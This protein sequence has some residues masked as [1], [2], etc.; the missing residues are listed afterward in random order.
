MRSIW[1]RA[2]TA[3]ELGLVIVIVAVVFWIVVWPW[4]PPRDQ[5]RRETCFSNCKQLASAFEMYGQDYDGTYPYQGPGL[6]ND[7]RDFAK[8][9]A[10]TNWI[11]AVLPYTKNDRIFVCPAAS[12]NV[13]RTAAPGFASAPPKLCS[14][15]LNGCFNGMRKSAIDRPSEKVMAF[16]WPHST[17]NAL[18]RPGNQDPHWRPVAAEGPR[19]WANHRLR[20]GTLGRNCF[21]GDGSARF[22]PE[23]KLTYAQFAVG[24]HSARVLPTHP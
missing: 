13:T 9:G 6:G 20:E 1:T 15:L 10:P 24:P 21:M 4:V 19:G 16:C 12:S 5:A 8:P 22:F 3:I 7:V 23:T 11:V 17:G 18:L 14:Y 2:L